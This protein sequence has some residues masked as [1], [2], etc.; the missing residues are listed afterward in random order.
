MELSGRST[1]GSCRFIPGEGTL[2]RFKLGPGGPQ[3]PSGPFEGENN[4]FT[5]LVVNKILI[6]QPLDCSLYRTGYLGC[7]RCSSDKW[8]NSVQGLSLEAHPLS[9]LS[10]I[11]H[12]FNP[13]HNFNTRISYVLGPV[14]GIAHVRTLFFKFKLTSPFHLRLALPSYFHPWCS[15]SKC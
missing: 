5:L 4:L 3:S 15:R 2:A 14:N 8:N 10:R 11:S 13:C 12:Y 9:K 1:E 6:F 7:F